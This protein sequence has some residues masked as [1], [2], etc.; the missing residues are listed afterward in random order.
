MQQPSLRPRQVLL[1]RHLPEHWQQY[2]L[3]SV[4]ASRRVLRWSP[5]PFWPVSSFATK[6]PLPATRHDPRFHQHVWNFARPSACH[7]KRR[8]PSCRLDHVSL[9]IAHVATFA[10]LRPSSQSLHI[11]SSRGEGRN[12][13]DLHSASRSSCISRELEIVCP[14]AHRPPIWQQHADFAFNVSNTGMHPMGPRREQPLC[15]S[16]E[17]FHTTSKRLQG[18]SYLHP[19]SVAIVTHTFQDRQPTSDPCLP[20][21]M[22]APCIGHEAG[23]KWASLIPTLSSQAIEATKPMLGIQPLGHM[24]LSFIGHEAR[25]MWDCYIT[26]FQLESCFSYN[27]SNT[28]TQVP[29]RTTRER[30]EQHMQTSSAPSATHPTRTQR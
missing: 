27:N 14:P 20:G 13:H 22:L 24:P 25:P 11:E 28:L 29:W 5:F 18:A 1:F 10:C 6:S 3:G 2:C 9:L 30:Q 19:L 17:V 7:W 23:P 21:H 12:R 26:Y 4:A 8:A 15:Y 16:W